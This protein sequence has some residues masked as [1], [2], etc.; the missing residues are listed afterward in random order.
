MIA[1]KKKINKDLK[2]EELFYFVH[3]RKILIKRRE[4]LLIK[5]TKFK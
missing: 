2:F 5:S 1:Q 4:I 3:F